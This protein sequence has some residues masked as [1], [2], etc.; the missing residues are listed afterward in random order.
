MAV[1][2]SYHEAMDVLNHEPLFA[3][4]NQVYTVSIDLS[5][6]LHFKNRND[7]LSPLWDETY[8][9]PANQI[10]LPSFSLKFQGSG[11][12]LMLDIAEAE[13]HLLGSKR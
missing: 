2:G 9:L 4:T 13:I 6:G 8:R 5:W 11:I 10:A 3:L 1:F 12:A 7:F